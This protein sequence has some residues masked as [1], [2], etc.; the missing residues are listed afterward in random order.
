MHPWANALWK[1][2]RRKAKMIQLAKKVYDQIELGHDC[3]VEV[4]SEKD[5][6][7]FLKLYAKY[8]QPYSAYPPP[9]VEIQ[10]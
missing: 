3:I 9:E 8:F 6:D 1:L 4:E 7:A 10:Q 5:K 2:S